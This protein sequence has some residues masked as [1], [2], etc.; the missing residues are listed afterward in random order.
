MKGKKE[1]KKAKQ[2]RALKEVIPA[3]FN[4]PVR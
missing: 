2:G 1:V 4:K 3:G